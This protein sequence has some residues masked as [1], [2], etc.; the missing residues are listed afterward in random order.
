MSRETVYDTSGH[1]I[2]TIPVGTQGL[3][4]NNGLKLGPLGDG[5]LKTREMIYANAGIGTEIEKVYDLNWESI[6]KIK[7]TIEP[8]ATYSYVPENKQGQLPLFD[9]VDRIEARSLISYGFT[10]R[11]YAKLAAR[12]SSQGQ[13]GTSA[14]DDNAE[15]APSFSPFRARSSVNGSSV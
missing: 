2:A 6:E 8:F 11:I 3:L 7:H 13:E 10:S 4:Y 9:Q 15:N 1:T 5:G 14:T 12:P